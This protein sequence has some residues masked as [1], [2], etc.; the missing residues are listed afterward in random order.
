MSWELNVSFLKKKLIGQIEVCDDYA[1][2]SET[3]ALIADGI[4]KEMRLYHSYYGQTQLIC[5]LPLKENILLS[6]PVLKEID[7]WLSYTKRWS[8]YSYI[9]CYGRDC[10]TDD[11]DDR[12][13]T[14][15]VKIAEMLST[16]RWVGSLFVLF[17]YYSKLLGQEGWYLVTRHNQYFLTNI[18]TGC[19]KVGIR[20][21]ILSLLQHT[22]WLLPEQMS[23]LF[24]KEIAIVAE[25][26]G[27]LIHR[28]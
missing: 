9:Q 17:R 14:L 20:D 5:T 7:R 2:P 23:D 25:Q 18:K 10:Y 24:R 22:R 6:E 1:S 12:L 11:T 3:T 28:K 26:K 13:S 4:L 27:K 19:F 8:H 21:K 16:L 15:R